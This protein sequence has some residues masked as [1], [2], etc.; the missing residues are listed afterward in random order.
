MT[1]LYGASWLLIA[2]PLAGAIVLLVGGRLLDRVG[3]LVGC[4]TVLAA[5]VARRGDLL[6]TSSASRPT[7]RLHE[8]PMFTWIQSGSLDIDFGLLHRPAVADLRAADHR[9]RRR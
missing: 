3:H 7:T 5:F 4:A 9:R 1:G 2:L 6:L 8:V